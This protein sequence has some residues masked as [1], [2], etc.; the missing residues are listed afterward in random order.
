MLIQLYASTLTS[1]LFLVKMP[2]LKTF[3]DGSVAVAWIPVSLAKKYLFLVTYEDL[4]RP[5]LILLPMRTR[6]CWTSLASGKLPLES[7]Q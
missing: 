7:G 5:A 3:K 4:Y 1:T 6:S 2:H